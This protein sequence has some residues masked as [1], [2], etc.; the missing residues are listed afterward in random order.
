MRK[1]IQPAALAELAKKL[2]LPREGQSKAAEPPAKIDVAF[3]NPFI[4]STLAVLETTAGVS[5]TKDSIFIRTD[6]ITSGDIS[7]VIAM[8]SVSYLGS[9]AITFE[10]KCFLHVVSTMLGEKYE[11][12]TVENQDAVSELCNQIFGR[13]KNI[14]NQQG[15]TIQ[16]AIPSLVVGRNHRIKHAAIGPCIAVKFT[17]SHGPFTV[18]A[19]VQSRK[20]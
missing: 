11:S 4:E 15:H 18:E 17:T 8:N 20:A 9:M 12:I 5:A 16:P 19:V 13:S 2:L 1:P 7:A 14:L 10:E 3:I 6:E